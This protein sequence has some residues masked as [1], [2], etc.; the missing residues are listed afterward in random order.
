MPWML[1][2]LLVSAVAGLSWWVIDALR[3]LTKYRGMAWTRGVAV[4]YHGVRDA[5]Q[6]IFLTEF[7][8][9]VHG[10]SYRMIDYVSFLLTCY[11]L[12]DEVWVRYDPDD[13]E[14][15]YV[16]RTW[17]SLLRIAGALLGL[18]VLAWAVAHAWSAP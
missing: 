4:A 17:P 3:E 18:L 13:V 8:Y 12:G 6:L 10:R 5:A 2:A 1:C 11:R 15:A 14:R 7:E 9:E 16:W